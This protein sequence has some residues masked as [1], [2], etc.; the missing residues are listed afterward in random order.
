MLGTNL[1]IRS[2]MPLLS[3]PQHMTTNHSATTTPC[4]AFAVSDATPLRR[5]RKT[6][7]VPSIESQVLPGEHRPAPEETR[8]P[9]GGDSDEVLVARCRVEL[10]HKMDAY[11]ELV[12]RH[13]PLVF[14]TCAKMIG[15]RADAEEVCQDAF[16]RVFN[17]LH[18][19]EGRSSFKTWLFRIVFN[20]CRYRRGQIARRKTRDLQFAEEVIVQAGAAKTEEKS[21][22]L[23]ECVRAALNTLDED[24]R[25]IVVMKFVSG[26]SIREISEVLGLELSATKMRLYR[27]LDQLKASYLRI[28]NRSA[29][30]LIARDCRTQ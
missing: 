12:R 5:I 28:V 20:M 21:W 6:G 9:S 15:N 16:L 3:A 23:S 25:R 22:D 4:V 13:E 7:S 24:K 1:A 26:L 2:A 27:T 14:N 19:F 29:E 11:E 17:K 30:G 8:S 10:P 18:Q